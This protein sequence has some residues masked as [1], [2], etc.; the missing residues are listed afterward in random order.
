MTTKKKKP[1]T[2]KKKAITSAAAVAHAMQLLTK[3]TADERA[4]ALSVAEAA[5]S[6]IDGDGEAAAAKA[7]SI[8]LELL[9][10]GTPPVLRSILADVAGAAVGLLVQ[11]LTPTALEVEA[12]E[13]VEVR[14]IVED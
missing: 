1:A 5:V 7:V 11:A 13:G 4:L 9:P 14:I 6:A 3:A 2:K 10:A 12:S 8:G